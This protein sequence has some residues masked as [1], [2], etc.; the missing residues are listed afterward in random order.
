MTFVAGQPPIETNIALEAPPPNS[1]MNIRVEP[2]GRTIFSLTFNRPPSEG[3]KKLFDEMRPRFPLV[4]VDLKIQLVGPA[5]GGPPPEGVGF[6]T[7]EEKAEAA[8]DAVQKL[9]EATN[10]E[11]HSLNDER[12][13][14]RQAMHE[15]TRD[16]ERRAE[17]LRKKIFDKT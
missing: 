4:P 11:A 3:W 13:K 14:K 12:D 10:A 1:Q 8:V 9:I 2:N 5:V 17:A 15:R 6:T 16:G 7:T